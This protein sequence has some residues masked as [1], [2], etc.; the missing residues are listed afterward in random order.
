MVQIENDKDQTPHSEK[1]E[2][3][4]KEYINGVPVTRYKQRATNEEPLRDKET[5]I[6]QEKKIYAVGYRLYKLAEPARPPTP[7][8]SDS[9][10]I[11]AWKSELIN[12]QS[13]EEVEISP[14]EVREMIFEFK[15]TDSYKNYDSKVTKDQE[16][17]SIKT[18]EPTEL[19]R[20]DEWDMMFN[21]WKKELDDFMVNET[22]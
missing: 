19:L 16:S 1:T 22:D 4:I 7:D 13:S 20:G 9:E 10:K 5:N 14:S 8:G 12:L 18:P 6:M 17:R 3:Q 15:N 2:K 21:V 11:K